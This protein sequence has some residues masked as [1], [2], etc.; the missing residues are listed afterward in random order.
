MSNNKN[1][2]PHEYA[3]SAADRASK[4]NQSPVLLWFTGYSGSGKSTLA[5]ALEA[6]LL[7]KGFHTFSLDGDNLRNRLNKDLGFSQE[8]RTE[9]L[10]RVAEVSRLFLDAGIIVL[11]AFVSP[12]RSQRNQV[13]EIVGHHKFVEI[14]VDTPLEVCEQRDVKGLYVKARAGEIKN[15][16]GIDS[17]YEKPESPDVIIS[18]VNKDVMACAKEVF[19]KIEE[20]LKQK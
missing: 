9:N 6:V 17:A 16:T 19:E 15:F 1:I 8:D 3:V 18:T 13:R 5:S 14:F 12:L 20:K 4:K 11:A 7:Q 2:V 10:R